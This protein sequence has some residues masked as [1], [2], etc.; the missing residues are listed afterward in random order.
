[1]HTSNSQPNQFHGVIKETDQIVTGTYELHIVEISPES[2]IK[3]RRFTSD[4]M[5]EFCENFIMTL[6]LQDGERIRVYA[7]PDWKHLVEV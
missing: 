7:S 5:I 4:E 6:E 1:M 2:M 3:I